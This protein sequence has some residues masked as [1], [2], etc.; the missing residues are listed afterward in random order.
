MGRFKFWIVAQAARN[1]L[2]LSALTMVSRVLGLLRDHFQAV[3]FGTGPVATAWEI[4]YMLPNMLRNLLAEG[5]LSQ[6]F[7]PVYSD[8]L[9]KSKEEASRAAGVVLLFILIG[10]GLLV[11][12]VI[13]F[14]PWFIPLYTGKT[15]GEAALTISLSQVMFPFILTVSLTAIFSGISNTH[16]RY[17]VP[18]LSPILLNIIFITGF[19]ILKPLHFD[20]QTNASWLSWVVV[21]GG[22]VQLLFQA[23]Y[24]YK[25]GDGPVFNWNFRHPALIKIFSLMAP[26][27]IGASLFQLNQL[28]DVALASYFIP[29]ETGA[30][31]ALRYAHR[32]IQL[33]TGI[34][35]VAVATTILPALVNSIRNNHAHRNGAELIDAASFTLFLTMPA[36]IGLFFLGPDIINMLFFGGAWDESSTA[37]TWKALIFYSMGVPLY[38]L[39]KI[40]T[41]SYYAYKDTR[42]PVSVMIKV[43]IINFFMNLVL[44]QFL[45]QG[46][47]A[48]SSAVSALLNSVMLFRGLRSKMDEIPFRKLLEFLNKAAPLW[49]FIILFLFT[50]KFIL[51]PW[52]DAAGQIFAD[53]AGPKEYARYKGMTVVIPSLILTMFFYFYGARLLKLEQMEMMLSALKRKRK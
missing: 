34:I 37:E 48:L 22:T 8:E 38:S 45:A 40:L 42:S 25:D 51:H 52:L 20:S 21:A 47:L 18:A 53:F 16:N 6:A 24:V 36:A 46:G 31:P 23:V 12:G 5:V 11:T 15:A 43:V 29:E 10:L 39:N 26:A 41:S 13:F 27:V 9:K 28:I 19:L 4:A 30:V 1:S 50:V 17:V 44:I 3:F 7:I 2:K 49:I 33:P 14:L 35:G 32:L